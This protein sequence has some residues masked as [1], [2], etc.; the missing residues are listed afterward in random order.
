MH[1]IHVIMNSRLLSVPLLTLKFH[2]FLNHDSNYLHSLIL[3]FLK[4]P[5]SPTIHLLWSL[6]SNI[7]LYS[8]PKMY[9]SDFQSFPYQY[10]WCMLMFFSILTHLSCQEEYQSKV[11]IAHLHLTSNSSELIVLSTIVMALIAIIYVEKVYYHLNNNP[12]NKLIIHSLL[13][14]RI[15]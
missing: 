3:S 10:D 14:F 6:K 12:L 13:I 2:M 9:S 7:K 15:T 5:I 11:D 4:L 8:Y 1:A